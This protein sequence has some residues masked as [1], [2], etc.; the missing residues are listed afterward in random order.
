MNEI[1]KSTRKDAVTRVLHHVQTGKSIS[2]ACREVGIPRSTYY[3]FLE[4]NPDVLAEFQ[5]AVK[6][7]VRMRLAILL[8]NDTEILTRIIEDAR[9]DSTSPRD[10]LAIYIALQKM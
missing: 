3:A 9:A 1:T 4:E 6:A 10:R 5:A 8:A 7:A 2:A